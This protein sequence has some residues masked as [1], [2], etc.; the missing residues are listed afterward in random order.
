L[1]PNITHHTTQSLQGIFLFWGLSYKQ[2]QKSNTPQRNT[3]QHI[4]HK[5]SFILQNFANNAYSNIEIKKM[6]IGF[7]LKT[8][9]LNN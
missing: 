3:T 7:F 8:K 1:S 2:E 9:K 6:W 4:K 5:V